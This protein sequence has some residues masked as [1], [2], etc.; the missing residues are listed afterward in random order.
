MPTRN[1]RDY[2]T[3]EL[4]ITQPA[5]Q[6]G[7]K[8]MILKERLNGIRKISQ[9]LSSGQK[10]IGKQQMQKTGKL[11]FLGRMSLIVSPTPDYH[12]K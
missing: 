8:K 1:V 9:V 7:S 6:V 10:T 12:H 3:Y 5:T 4:S 11:S 2:Q